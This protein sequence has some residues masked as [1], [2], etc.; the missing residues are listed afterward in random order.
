MG[1]QDVTSDDK[2]VAGPPPKFP[3]FTRFVWSLGRHALCYRPG[4]YTE[5]FDGPMPR[6]KCTSHT[7]R[8]QGEASQPKQQYPQHFTNGL[9]IVVHWNARRGD[10]GG[11][12]Q[13]A[14][15][16][17]PSILQ[18]FVSVETLAEASGGRLAKTNIR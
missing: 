3:L 9:C 16:W 15:G 5:V 8:N 13:E 14:T 12:I 11:F 7:A 18:P 2:L 6:P 17:K 4:H 1:C 10:K